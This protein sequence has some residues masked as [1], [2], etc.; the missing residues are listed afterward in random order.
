M[1]TWNLSSPHACTTS[2][3]CASTAAVHGS[4]SRLHRLVALETVVTAATTV[5]LLLHTVKVSGPVV[6]SG[7][8][9]IA[10]V[11]LV[12]VAIGIPLVYIAALVGV[13]IPGPGPVK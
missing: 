5:S 11:V 4:W 3:P 6:V 12:P 7:L 9:I 2:W 13:N 8:P 1:I 10:F